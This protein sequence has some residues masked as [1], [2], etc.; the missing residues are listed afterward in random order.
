[1]KR[2]NSRAIIIVIMLTT[3]LTATYSD[4]LTWYASGNGGVVAAGAQASTRAGIGVLQK[5]G[6]AIDAAVATIFN[7]AIADFGLFCIG[8]EVP[9]MFYSSKTKEV[10]VFNGMGGA[11]GDPKA[12]EWYYSNGIPSTGIKSATVPSAVSTLLTALEQKGSMSFEQVIEPTLLLL[13]A[14]G[15]KWYPNLAATLRKLVQTEK[16]TTG[17]REQKIRAARDRFYK[18]DIADELNSYYISSG[19]FLRKTDLA[20]HVTG[21][22]KPVSIKYRGYTVNKCNTW[23]QGPVLLQSLRLLEN[24]DLKSLGAFS[25]DYI[26]ITLE[27]MKLAYADRDKYYGDPGFVNVPIKQLLSDEYTRIRYPLIDIKHASQQIRP[28]D[29]IKMEA[30]SGPGQYWPGEKGTTT[31]VV[32]DRWGNIVAATPSANPDYGICESLG[33]AH[34]TRLS[35]LNTQKGHP[36]ALEAGKRPRIT[37]TPTIVLK[38]GNPF[39]GMSVAGGDM[40]DQ[41]S[42]QLLIDLIDFG[43]MPKDAVTAPRFLTKHIQDS[44]NPS[45]DPAVRMGKIS[46]V[47]INSDDTSHT[48]NLEARG[49]KVT[50]SDATL[51]WPVMIYLDQKTGI[52]YGAGQPAKDGGGKTCAAINLAK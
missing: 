36:N 32:A 42:L 1:M 19:G 22:E 20:A 27:A 48:A 4:D 18:G 43:M 13:D 40:Q 37:L 46:G 8:G 34:N 9:F 14:G 31:C 15:E 2:I 30:F 52:S 29:P 6:N 50:G 45:P 11:P 28:G 21:V 26:H 38:D 17:T 5:E 44:F 7:L 25:P 39:L 23:T 24:F 10:I 51:G 33:I 49:H 47:E 3:C 16:S 35:S 12:I 41:V